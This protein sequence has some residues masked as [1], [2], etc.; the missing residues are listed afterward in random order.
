MASNKHSL[1]KIKTQIEWRSKYDFLSFD[2]TTMNCLLCTKYKDHARIIIQV[3]SM[4]VT[5]FV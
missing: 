3:L 2:T 1:P 5:I 4:A